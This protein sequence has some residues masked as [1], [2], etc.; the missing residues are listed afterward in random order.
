MTQAERV[1]NTTFVIIIIIIINVYKFSV[2]LPGHE[3]LLDS[4]HRC[5]TYSSVG[6]KQPQTDV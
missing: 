1:I 3:L 6:E 2:G 5:V 4:E